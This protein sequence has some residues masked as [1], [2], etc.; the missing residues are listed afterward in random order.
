M[1]L[2]LLCLT[3]RNKS[4]LRLL[5]PVTVRVTPKILAA[6]RLLRCYIFFKIKYIYIERGSLRV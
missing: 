3:L 4:L 5:R 6:Q 2:G 1:Q